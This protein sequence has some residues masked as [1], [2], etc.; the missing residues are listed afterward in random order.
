MNKGEILA[1]VLNNF[2]DCYLLLHNTREF[3]VVENIM[4][5]GFIFESQLPNT[6]DHINPND[7]IEISYFLIR[8]KDY[9]NYTVIIAIPGNIYDAYSEAAIR[10]DLTFEE[11]ITTSEPYYSEN[12]E[13]VFTL[14]QKHVLG[15]FNLKSEEFY[16]NINWDPFFNNCLYRTPSKRLQ[17]KGK[18]NC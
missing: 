16:R 6:A 15:Y 3:D 12:D 1:S 8:R 11:V 17:N 5:K 10:N 9:G 18:K 7:P 13:L 4:C 2:S 14:S